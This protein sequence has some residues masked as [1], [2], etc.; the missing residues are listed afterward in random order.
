LARI[1]FVIL[2]AC[3]S[4]AHAQTHVTRLVLIVPF[5]NHSKAPGLEWVSESFPE[6]MGRTLSKGR[7]FVVSRQ[8]RLYAFD[9][10]GIPTGVQLSRAT[11]LRIA[12]EMD[13]DFI[14][15][16]SFDYDRRGFT[17][18]AQVMDVNRLRLSP[19]AA[20]SGALTQTVEIESELA[21]AVAR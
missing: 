6:V 18:H 14:V 9:R 16:G 19:D 4:A 1:F 21:G 10:L 8:A 7:L 17:A 5:E 2:L 12:Q 15:S 3:A 13:V 20:E 11:L